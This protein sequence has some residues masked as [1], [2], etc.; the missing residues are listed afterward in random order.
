MTAAA[1]KVNLSDKS[2][3]EQLNKRRAGAAWQDDAW[4]FYDAVGEIKYAFRLFSNV[5]SRIRLYAAVIEDEDSTPIP[6][7]EDD[8]L[9]D[10][11]KRIINRAMLRVFPSSQQPNLLRK[12]GIN[13]LVAGECYLI[14]LPP[15]YGVRDKEQWK[16]VSVNELVLKNGTYKLKTEKNQREMDME[17]IP[18]TAFVGRIWNEHA[19]YSDEADS[20]MKALIELCE[21]LFLFSR[22]A[23]ATARSRLNAGAF[24]V[25][26]SM[27]VSSSQVQVVADAVDADGQPIVVETIEGESDDEFEEELLDAMTTPIADESSAASVVPLLIRGPAEAGKEIRVIKFERSF[28]PQLALRAERALERILQGID[29]PKDIVTGLANIKYSNAVQIEESLYTAHVE[30]LVLMICD[31]FRAVYL[32]PALRAA[33]LD[34]D[35]IDRVVLWYDPAAI[36]TAPDKSNA[37]NVGHDKMNLSD[38]AWRRANGF[39]ETDAPTE[40]EIARRLAISRGA[41]SEEITTAILKTIM[42]TILEAARAQSLQDSP[43]PLPPGVQEVLGGPPKPPDDP[44]AAPASPTPPPTTP[45]NDEQVLP[46]PP[47]VSG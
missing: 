36:M 18:P 33:G 11:T 46:P 27:S 32:E 22:A 30:P 5:L 1:Q 39:A 28:D 26:D 21:D 19:R 44:T 20:S 45:G 9:D 8:S 4:E 38:A 25:P 12:T 10:N 42:P 43:S 24:F 40:D 16:I 17:D 29:L 14:Q 31:A 47:P 7:K 23:R 34:E 13:L 3:I 6:V 37:A 41:L 15:K 2:A 35:T